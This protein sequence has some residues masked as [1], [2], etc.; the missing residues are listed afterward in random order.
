[1]EEFEYV[2]VES[3]IK[4]TDNYKIVEKT[5]EN[6]NKRKNLF[7]EGFCFKNIGDIDYKKQYLKFIYINKLVQYNVS[8]FTIN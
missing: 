7:K 1:M 3:L 2:P 5:A 8:I 6:I 4:A